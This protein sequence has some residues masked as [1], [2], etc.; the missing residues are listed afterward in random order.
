MGRTLEGLARVLGFG[1]LVGLMVPTLALVPAMVVDRGFDG[2]TRV[3]AFPAALVVL[4][5]LVW[6][7]VRNSVAVA[8]VVTVGSLVVGTGLG[9]VLGRRRF[10]GRW[11]LGILAVVP[12]AVGP[13]WVAPGVVAWIGGEASWEWL[14]ARSFLGRPGDDW[15]R[16][17]ALVWVGLVGA[18]PLVILATRA[19]L[20]RID[21]AW[22]DAARVVGAGRLRVWLDVTW[23]TLRPE[24]ARLA[25]TIFALTLVEPAGPT[26]LGLRRTL[27]VEMA[28]A[29]LRFE[30]PNRAATLAGI[31]VLISVAARRLLVRW[32]GPVSVAPIGRSDLEPEPRAGKRLGGFAAFALIFWVGF[33]L[34]PVVDFAGRLVDETLHHRPVDEAELRSVVAT[35]ANPEARTWAIN[36][37]VTASL[38]VGLDLILLA[39]LATGMRRSVRIFRSIPP[40]AMAVGALAVPT[41]LATWSDQVGGRVLAETLRGLRVE[42]STGRF[43]GFLLVVVL[44]AVRLPTL[45]RATTWN[46]VEPTPAPTDAALLA[47]ASS[48]E[49]RRLARD[50]GGFVAGG[51]IILA[52]TWAAT[53]LASAWVLTALDERRTLASAAL[54][55][56]GGGVGPL[57]PRLLGLFVATT[58]IKLA[59]LGIVAGSGRNRPG[60]LG[61]WFA[62]E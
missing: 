3:S 7:C 35:W 30:Q 39:C 4:D 17:L 8:S 27:V 48:R 10:W 40:M 62:G 19:G 5:P 29:A 23:P 14:A 6:R 33:S 58:A 60:R 25:S 49:A 59:A 57:D 43:P 12:L 1:L 38:A 56:V 42:L 53:D 20:S 11:P 18:T 37:A 54:H 44:A 45:V 26:I 50:G 61:D 13:I 16:W 47:G 52:W 36:S 46:Q 28:D 51:P 24:L 22:A 9:L 31:A 15:A 21:P 2:L 41:L 55:L 34:G 32:G